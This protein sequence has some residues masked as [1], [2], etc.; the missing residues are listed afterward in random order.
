MDV[1]LS[2]IGSKD[3]FWTDADGYRGVG[4][5]LSLLQERQFE[6]V[7]LFFNIGPGWNERAGEIRQ[8]CE[9]A[10]RS[11]EVVYNP[12]DVMDVTNH[13][14]LYRVMNHECQG[15]RARYAR[16]EARFWVATASG[17]PAMQT[18]WV[19]LVQSGL[20]P[21]KLLVTTPP[22]YTRPGASS[23]REVE[24]NLDNF[25]QI[26]SPEAAKRQLSILQDQ[27]QA[28]Q[29]QNAALQAQAVQPFELGEE[30]VDLLDALRQTETAYFRLA[31]QRCDGNAA[32]AASLLKID[33]HAFR[34]R[35]VD[36]KILERKTQ[37]GN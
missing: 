14:E 9:D 18:I 30:G 29:A 25:P 15:I 5:L 11:E 24:L 12:L 3:P 21:A 13:A 37:K 32:R 35:A 17:T 22:R 27:I 7:H 16:R 26:Q 6:A 1:L 23:V 8:A 4:P 20:F 36:L 2:F 34:K 31:L 10:K 28:L 19:L 33:P